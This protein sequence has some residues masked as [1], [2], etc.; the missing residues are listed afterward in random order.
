MENKYKISI[1]IV[2]IISILG[3]FNLSN[4]TIAYSEFTESLENEN[5]IPEKE[6]D[7][8]WFD[9]V[10]TFW[11]D[12]PLDNPL[13][14]KCE[15]NGGSTQ[16]IKENQI[17]HSNVLELYR[18]DAL[19]RATYYFP[20]STQYIWEWSPDWRDVGLG[21]LDHN[22][23][24]NFEFWILS[25]GFKV[26]TYEFVLSDG[27]SILIEFWDNQVLYSYDSITSEEHSLGTY[28]I[29]TWY[30]IRLC[31]Y[32]SISENVCYNITI[33]DELKL[34]NTLMS[35]DDLFDIYGNEYFDY[36]QITS[37]SNVMKLYF[38][39][40]T[41]YY[42]YN[43]FLSIK[44][45]YYT[46]IQ[47]I[48]AVSNTN[49]YSLDTNKV[50]SLYD[51]MLSVKANLDNNYRNTFITDNM[52][53]IDLLNCSRVLRMKGKEQD[54]RKFKVIQLYFDA[55]QNSNAF[56]DNYNQSVKIRLD[57]FDN[58]NYLINKFFINLDFNSSE[59]YLTWNWLY[60]DSIEIPRWFSDLHNP[61]FRFSDYVSEP[62]ECFEV[63]FQIF[64]SYNDTNMLLNIRT[65]IAFNHDYDSTYRYD[66]IIDAGLI[67]EFYGLQDSLQVRYIDYF[68]NNSGIDY[69]NNS[70]YT[71]NNLAGLRT[72]EINNTDFYYNF[73]EVGYYSDV[74]SYYEPPIPEP[75][76]PP[77]LTPDEPEKPSGFDFYWSYNGYVIQEL[78]TIEIEI[79]NITYEFTRFH[80]K[81]IDSKFWF[82]EDTI[83]YIGNT[84]E[85]WGDWGINNWMRNLI[86]AATRFMA[87][88][89]IW[90]IN[91]LLF[92]FQIII[93]GITVLFNFLIMY[94]ILGW[95][96]CNILWNVGIYYIMYA[97]VTI[98]WSLF[99][100]LVWF[101]ESMV[102]L[103]NNVLLPFFEWFITD[104][105]PAF[106]DFVIWAVSW[107]LAFAIWCF[108]LGTGDITMIFDNI[109]SILTLVSD[110]FM[111]L[112]GFFVFYFPYFITWAFLY[113]YL[114]FLLWVKYLYYKFKGY[115]D[116][117]KELYDVLQT[118][119][120]PIKFI[121]NLIARLRG[122][123]SNE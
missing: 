65:D 57:S 39:S 24:L 62:I 94:L 28:A 33:N 55:L 40:L 68:N 7:S 109:F 102:W 48:K 53:N 116:Q 18:N 114:C 21:H 104:F 4:N 42:N 77:E 14:W 47:N 34:S 10:E 103:W 35:Y 19:S 12:K 30:H 52:I 108:T 81:R 67:S 16:Y 80:S 106:V 9:G 118:Y 8:G 1:T 92:V 32:V 11:Y 100:A 119:L 63:D 41:Y 78:D 20:N 97:L 26:G 93:Y 112:I 85:D 31:L 86:F 75:P 113:I 117:A 61:N 27:N 72:L 22:V 83:D 96:V 110:E 90:L 89:I 87:N 38:D 15:S 98:L 6:I 25:N 120:F 107:I 66:K 51:S 23:D 64:L 95:V 99:L 29:N 70:Y 13:E 71:F 59:G 49:R 17:S 82:N 73:L 60:R 56:R 123:K 101:I 3:V 76:P 2:F 91:G 111:E 88:T 122:A 74:L 37:V 115:N 121:L 105:L 58:S 50:F 44:P 46:Q 5:Y 45:N 79:G 54:N 69:L 84:P 36:L 43:E